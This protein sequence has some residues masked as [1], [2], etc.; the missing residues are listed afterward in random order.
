MVWGS[1]A[2]W[3]RKSWFWGLAVGLMLLIGF[4]RIYLGVHFPTDVLAGWAIGAL[5]LG[6]YMSMRP[7][8]Q[9]WLAGLSLGQQ[10]LLALGV[11][12][13]LLL[14][15][16]IKDAALTTGALAGSG[17]GIVLTYRYAPFSARG[18]W[19]QR[20]LR[21]LTGGAIVILLYGG[22]KM[23]L[24]G[25][26]SALNLAFRFLRFGLIGLWSSLGAPWL[27]RLLRLVP[28]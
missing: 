5:S 8:V 23:V 27:F 22:L 9:K 10:M 13:V 3:S 12:L 24:P 1:I 4:S 25:E 21:F 26:E 15:Y 6:L 11:P 19:W 16:P 28:N 20:I 2:A 14:I 18:P 17:V 7:S